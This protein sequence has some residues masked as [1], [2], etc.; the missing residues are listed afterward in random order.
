MNTST[1]AARQATATTAPAWAAPITLPARTAST[2][3]PPP[4]D[5][6]RYRRRTRARDLRAG[7]LTVIGWASVAASVALYLAYGGMYEF[8]TFPHALTA[9]GIIAGLVATDLMCLML[10]LAARI[11]YVERCYGHDR[12]VALHSRL[13]TWV[14]SGLGLH[15]ALLIVGYA[16]AEGVSVIEETV[17]LWSVTDVMLGFVA[18]GLLA[19]VAVSSVIA[20]KRALGYEA[21]HVIHLTTYVAVGLSIPHQF[22]MSGLFAD[23]TWQ[24]WYWIG[25]YGA[26][27]ISLLAFRVLLPLL[28]T[29]Q[30]GLVVTR[31]V[32]EAHDV[33]SIE[34]RGRHLPELDVAGGQFLNWRFLAKGLWWHQHPF[35]VSAAPTADTLRVTVRNL[36]AGTASL[37][38]L[39]PGT[40]V[41]VEGPYGTFTDA[42]RT[43]SGLVLVGFGIG[44]APVRALLEST[45][46][47][48]G[49]ATVILRASR[50]DE[51]YLVREIEALCRQRG[52]RLITLVGPR[53]I[54]RTGEASW[55]PV[56]HAGLGLADLV[57]HLGQSDVYVCGPQAAT[58]L[59][60]AEALAAGVPAGAIHDERFS[61]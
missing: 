1:L 42:A 48:P 11:P 13:G 60:V 33:V 61:W 18:L 27:V 28:S 31:V 37:M 46:V 57:P 35:S 15:A 29:A 3:T 41:M 26:T 55:V 47:V 4:D 36:G 32:R 30:H 6:A 2:Q 10:L 17:S 40:K 8:D 34:M 16:A 25:L 5:T 53:A 52:A 38:D 23:G 51:L 56:S 21:W 22:S 19:A 59:V 9:L 39:Q 49:K 45:E 58:D 24:R 43:S 44:I 7:S 50:P 54:R 20:V 14:L 12:T